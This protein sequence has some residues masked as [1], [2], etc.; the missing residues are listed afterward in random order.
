MLRFSAFCGDHL[1]TFVLADLDQFEHSSEHLVVHMAECLSEQGACLY[2][3]CDLRELSC[4]LVVL[5]A[6]ELEQ[7]DQFFETLNVWILD[8]ELLDCEH[9][10]VA[11]GARW[12]VSSLGLSWNSFLSLLY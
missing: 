2:V 10:G 3:F 11:G 6:S 5:F 7:I 1:T 8:S 9:V 12:G 4:R